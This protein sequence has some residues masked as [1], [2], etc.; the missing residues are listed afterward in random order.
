MG[1][2]YSEGEYITLGI[3]ESW[4]TLKVI[5]YLN[6]NYNIGNIIIWGRS[7][8]AVTAILAAEHQT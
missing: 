7:M 3:K 5:E 8:G 1:S 2:G 4:D 6:K